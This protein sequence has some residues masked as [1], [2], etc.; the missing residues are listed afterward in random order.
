MNCIAIV[1]A[2]LA[3]LNAALAL[4]EEGF[5]GRLV[6]VGDEHR[7]PYDR[8]PLSK[9]IVRGEWEV[10]RTNLAFEE[11]HLRAEWR[12]GVA[13]THLRAAERVLGFSDGVEEQ[14]DGIV[15][16][17]GAAPRRIPG[18]L[19][20]GV[21]VLRTLDAALG[22]QADLQAGPQNVVVVG[23]GFIG[24]EVAAS[25]RGLGLTV[26]MVEAMLPA[27]A[28]LGHAVALRLADMHRGQGV[29]L[30]S[31][32][33]VQDL[34][35]NGRVSCVRLSDG[36]KLTAD[37]VVIGIGVTPNT[38]WLEGSGL[39]VDNGI[40]CD[41]TCLAAPGIVAAGDVA[42][43]PNHR[44]GEVR[45]VEH[46]DN[47][48]RQAKHAARRLLAEEGSAAA[49]EPYRPVPWVWSDQYGRKLQLVGST[50]AHEE[51]QIVPGDEAGDRFVALYRRGDRLTGAF[52]MNSA[53]RIL[54]Y[55]KM[56][57]SSP[58]WEDVVAAA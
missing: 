36:D 42:R 51:V 34:Q 21:H 18:H 9:E 20:G 22:L 28:A 8:P 19:L 7:R 47:A 25:C 23:G 33:G 45:R 30:K 50:L 17:T 11:A 32:C 27:Q 1:G 24:Q 12:L 48:I 6:I 35:G 43:W 57:E 37:V 49:V 31:D 14:F 53:G 56:L 2:S 52:G 29:T 5:E 58:L 4:R 41:E 26:T 55:R 40:L 13:A 10:A 46:W 15:I 3:G 16:A 44:F 54:H 38:G 39:F